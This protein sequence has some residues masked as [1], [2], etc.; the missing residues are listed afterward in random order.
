MLSRHCGSGVPCQEPFY[1][2]PVYLFSAGNHIIPDNYT[3]RLCSSA[4]SDSTLWS[5]VCWVSMWGVESWWA[6]HDRVLLF[7]IRERMG[8]HCS[9]MYS[10]EDPTCYRVAGDR[11]QD[12]DD[13]GLLITSR[14][15]VGS[16]IRTSM[17]RQFRHAG[18][19][20]GM[21]LVFTG[22]RVA[23]A[24]PFSFLVPLLRNHFKIKVLHW[25]LVK[26]TNGGINYKTKRNGHKQ[27]NNHIRD[28]R[29][30]AIISGPFSMIFVNVV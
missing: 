15:W 17:I 11:D 13:D 10:W 18:P 12:D 19:S 23:A 1:Q 8:F 28:L 5:H 14:H 21:A 9:L 25:D 27:N 16:P 3:D 6:G 2:Y 26:K 22:P 30:W 7:Q 20:C 24:T 29:E 4:C